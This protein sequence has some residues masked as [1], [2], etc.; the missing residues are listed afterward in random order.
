[1]EA[2]LSSLG[3]GVWN[4]SRDGYIASTTPPTNLNK[5][6]LYK[7]NDKARNTIMSGLVGSKLVKMMHCG[8]T[9]EIWE[10]LNNIYEGDDKV[11]KIKMKNFKLKFENL[12]MSEYEDS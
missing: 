10:K 7:N 9:K 1:M 2:Y 5:I 12:R 3:F 8:T 11:E 6:R 4:S